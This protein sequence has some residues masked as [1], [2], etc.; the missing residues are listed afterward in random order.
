[1]VTFR[2]VEN[3]EKHF[4]MSKGIKTNTHQ[5]TMTRES[6]RRIVQSVGL[7]S[8]DKQFINSYPTNGNVYAQVVSVQF[9]EHQPQRSPE[10]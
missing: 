2:S 7:Q 3:A 9:M 8:Q 10:R 6:A 4:Q 5:F 1:M